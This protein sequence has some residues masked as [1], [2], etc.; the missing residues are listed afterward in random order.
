MAAYGTQAFLASLSTTL[1]VGS[2]IA[3]AAS[4]RRFQLYDYTIG[5]ETN[6]DTMLTWIIAK[7]TGAA[8]GGTAPA[9][10]ALDS[11]DTIASTIVANQAPTTN[12]AGSGTVHRRPLYERATYRWVATPGRELVAPATASNGWGCGTPTSTAIAGS[13]SFEFNE[14]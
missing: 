11:S 2:I 6:G 7:R 8:T 10:T 1:D 12:G 4:P 5:S 3:A 13:I 14:L 9:I